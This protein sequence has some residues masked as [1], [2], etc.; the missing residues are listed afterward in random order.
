M[1]Q[2]SNPA[3]PSSS[4]VPPIDPVEVILRLVDAFQ[5][6]PKVNNGQKDELMTSFESVTADPNCKEHVF[7]T[8]GE[9]V[10]CAYFLTKQSSNR[11]PLRDTCRATID[12]L[13]RASVA[14]GI[15]AGIQYAK[16]NKL[17]R[18]LLRKRRARNSMSTAPA[19]EFRRPPQPSPSAQQ[20]FPSN[21][22]TPG[23]S[24]D[25]RIP[26]NSIDK[27]AHATADIMRSGPS[28][29]QSPP[30][31][32]AAT[33]GDPC[34]TRISPDS[35]DNIAH[36]N[37]NITLNGSSVPRN[38]P[39][40][41][42]IGTTLSHS[43]DTRIFP[44]SVA[45][46]ARTTTDIPLSRSSAHRFHSPST[47]APSGSTRPTTDPFI[48][49]STLPAIGTTG[50]QLLEQPNVH[51]MANFFPKDL[52][53]AIA[54]APGYIPQVTLLFPQFWDT[55]IRC[56]LTIHMV[57][58]GIQNIAESLFRASVEVENSLRSISINRTKIDPTPKL[59]LRSYLRDALATVFGPDLFTAIQNSKVAMDKDLGRTN[60]VAMDVSCYA[61]EWA[62]ITIS[63]D[64]LQAIVVRK[65]LFA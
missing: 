48:D 23:D 27:M 20:P 33:P 11:G 57:G 15:A 47:N 13:E 62:A 6:A 64:P 30:P 29:P 49:E 51:S 60:L 44:S 53:H 25:A 52:F 59:T 43:S 58:R 22:T 26:P 36:T 8:Y 37:T 38:T 5:R 24:S 1:V 4:A 42:I 61:N 31:S 55:I 45:K 41:S 3:S 28:A 16:R 10:L 19:K 40:C 65:K 39:P 54:I 50:Q 56:E 12:Q 9:Y 21:T 18:M 2:P 7:L 14:S 35:I 17:E 32:D 63:I 34:D 46:A